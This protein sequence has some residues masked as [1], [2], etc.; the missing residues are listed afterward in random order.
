VSKVHAPQSQANKT[1]PATGRTLAQIAQ[2]AHPW[3][4]QEIARY[5]WATDDPNEVNRVLVEQY[6]CTAPNA[7]PDLSPMDPD[8]APSRLPVLL[9][10]LWKESSVPMSA[11]HT[12]VVKK[13]KPAT[14]IGITKL[15]KWFIPKTETCQ[16]DYWLEGIQARASMVDL[17]VWASNYCEVTTTVTDGLQKY[18]FTPLDV[19]V[20]NRQR[21]QNQA[22]ERVAVPV[23]DWNG[24]TDATQGAMKKR[25]PNR[26]INVAGS[27]YTVMLRYRRPGKD[28][29]AA[30]RLE[31]F[32]P[33]FDS[34]GTVKRESLVVKWRIVGC[35]RFKAG[36]VLIYDRTD[37]IV[38]RKGLGAADVSEGQHTYNWGA[39][40][41]NTVAVTEGNMPYRVQVQAHT[42]MNDDD[43][44]GL[45][46]MHTEVRMY[47]HS[48]YGSNADPKDDTNSLQ[49]AIAPCQPEP[50]ASLTAGNF[51][52][53][54]RKLADAGFHPGPAHKEETSETFER[55]LREFQFSYPAG[56]GP[57]WNRLS[58][59]GQRNGPTQA[60]LNAL[61]A[62]ERKLFGDAANRG[63]IDNATA[64]PILN[65]PA[66]E[67]IVW[68]DDRHCYTCPP[69]EAPN[70]AMAMNNY[71]G[72]MTIGDRHKVD[73]K[74][75][76]EPWL[77][78]EVQVALLS[79]NDALDLAAMPAVTADMREAIGPLRIDWTFREPGQDFN[80]IDTTMYHSERVRT[81]V[82]VEFIAGE[83]E[84]QHDGRTVQNCPEKFGGIRPSSASSYYKTPYG[85]KE[86]SLAPWY[87]LSDSGKKNVYSIV[88]DDVG[89]PANDLFATHEGKAGM[90]LHLSRI[91]GDG[92]RFRAKVGFS[93][94]AEGKP[95]PNWKTLEQRYPKVPQAHTCDLRIWRKAS[96]RGHVLWAPN[97]E[98]H[99]G[100]LGLG[101]GTP[102]TS[103]YKGTFVHFVMERASQGGTPDSFTVDQL[104]DTTI[105]QDVTDFEDA[106]ANTCSW[107]ELTD[108]TKMTL[109]TQNLWPWL[110]EPHFGIQH[111]P[112][113][114]TEP[115]DYRNRYLTGE[116]QNQTWRKFRDRLVKVLVDKVEK[117][118]GRMRGHLVVEFHSSPNYA[119]QQYYCTTCGTWQCLL[120]R[121]GTWDSGVGQG[122]HVAG[123]A[124]VLEAETK[125]TYTCGACGATT[126]EIEDK[127]AAPVGRNCT[128][129]GNPA[130]AAG[131]P[132]PSEFQHDPGEALPW[133]HAGMAL[134]G[135]FV[136]SDDA[137]AETWAH[138]FAH[139]R[140]LEHAEQT[141]GKKNRKMHDS[142]RNRVAADLP[143]GDSALRKQWDRVCVMGYVR[144][145][146]PK[147]LKYF[148]GKCLLKLRGWAVES[149][150]RPDGDV[151]T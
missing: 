77:P 118:H 5:N 29:D 25:A 80:A 134:S 95:H 88:H 44:L 117:K 146:A 20:V 145:Q 107:A 55:S 66:R 113:P 67:L 23:R 93:D 33:Q 86:E 61:A 105:P 129:A 123:C 54:K 30:L 63:D 43:G 131:A 130:M 104:I 87:A 94:P 75:I 22:N 149:L 10:T 39:D 62:E 51:K 102:F 114:G 126:T 103:F 49:F 78:V 90:Y 140:H 91:A 122:C 32:W 76:C 45:A 127:A 110:G 21:P 15:D 50:A 143:G 138:E 142:K 148:C 139:H 14:A 3:T 57:P 7:Q 42:D 34:S 83:H 147:D 17:V 112:S 100:T 151:N 89:Q 37:A 65:D 9:P 136:C 73:A 109:D 11:T 69:G 137:R 64:G 1:W 47:A 84:A 125:V 2:T 24:E 119:V 48:D 38:F 16:L 96:L 35:G 120:E 19:P 144:H 141:G 98:N 12:I 27:P 53:Y 79:R 121:S 74:S 82:Y 111:I 135:L 116:V 40:P 4:W 13:R 85:L 72:G 115:G 46:A 8:K 150:A 92:Y 60:A 81:K 56:G 124:G 59:D 36:Q 97:G 70:A 108:R 41:N 18:S 133:N 26:Y 68:V 52:W 101:G 6:G 28:K 58:G 128:C 31:P 106:F 99:W 71:R 132:D